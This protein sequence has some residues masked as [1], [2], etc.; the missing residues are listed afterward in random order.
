[1]SQIK[2]VLFL[3]EKEKGHFSVK[4]TRRVRRVAISKEDSRFSLVKEITGIIE[5][6]T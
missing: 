3:R 4:G 6:S 1:M 2:K 5:E